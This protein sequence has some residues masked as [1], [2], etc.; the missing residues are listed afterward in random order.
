MDDTSTHH[1][2]SLPTP[3]SLFPSNPPDN[4]IPIPR[5]ILCAGTSSN[6]NDSSMDT[7]DSNFSRVSG[8]HPPSPDEDGADA[9]D[10]SA[11]N[12]SSHSNTLA[13]HSRGPD[14]GATGRRRRGGRPHDDSSPV[15]TSPVAYNPPPNRMDIIRPGPDAN[16]GGDD[17]GDD[18][19][20]IWDGA[21]DAVEDVTEDAEQTTAGDG[22]MRP[23]SLTQ[24]TGDFDTPQQRRCAAAAPTSRRRVVSSQPPSPTSRMKK[25]RPNVCDGSEVFIFR[26]RLV[27][28]CAGE[29][30]YLR[31]YIPT[32]VED[33]YRFWGRNKGKVPKNNANRY[34]IELE[35]FP[36]DAEGNRIAIPVDRNKFRVAF[37]GERNEPE[38][39]FDEVFQDDE[40]AKGDRDPK[41][42][43][44]RNFTKK[45]DEEVLQETN[46]TMQM[47]KE[48]KVVWQIVPEDEDVDLGSNMFPK[49][50]PE[51]Q[52][53]DWD[54]STPFEILLKNFFPDLDGVAKKM[55]EYNWDPRNPHRS[56]IVKEN[57]VFDDP[58]DPDPDWKVKQALSLLIRGTL[59]REVSSCCCLLI[60]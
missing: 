39:H 11:S 34:F 49:T 24:E 32:N 2:I 42:R 19:M 35:I 28:I 55:D 60:Q 45:T 3:R 7:T 22:A 27:T 8:L 48:V 5:E 25:K 17:D 41:T 18:S 57:V 1:D 58:G 36:R 43:S 59:Y 31:K 9:D 4:S 29:H 12:N 21:Y 6:A 37:D 54:G 30:E 50:A 10:N 40:R 20:P 16:G 13:D 14:T 26:N 33:K 53:I 38:E 46:F 51:L 56:T 44:T 23:A 52:G 15:P 47:D